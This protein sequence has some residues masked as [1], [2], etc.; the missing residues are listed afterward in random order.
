MMYVS[1]LTFFLLPVVRTN[2]PN[3]SKKVFVVPMSKRFLTILLML[4]ALK[5][6][7][8]TFLYAYLE[9]NIFAIKL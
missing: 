9:K 7:F 2:R 3:F 6:S 5:H 8:I 1:C 4:V